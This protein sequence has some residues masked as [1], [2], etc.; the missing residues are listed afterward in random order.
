MGRAAPM[1]IGEGTSAAGISS[2]V[3]GRYAVT[4]DGQY[5]VPSDW[6]SRTHVGLDEHGTG[7]KRCACMDGL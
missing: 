5:S 2:L 1:G 4:S 3:C 6:C 7:R